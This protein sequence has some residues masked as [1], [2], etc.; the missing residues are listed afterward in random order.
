MLAENGL[1]PIEEI[2]VGDW[3][4]S[5]D[6]QTGEE[7]WEQV[8]RVFQR[9]T[10]ALQELSFIDSEGSQ[11]GI[12]ATAEHPFW[13]EPGL[14]VAAG[15]LARGQKVW[16]RSG[17]AEVQENRSQP[18]VKLVFNFEVRNFHT[19]FVGN[20]GL[21][22]HNSCKDNG[23]KPNN[24]DAKPHGSP[25]HNNA[26]DDYIDN[27]PDSSKNIRKNQAQVDVNG[28]KVGNN[29]PDVQFDDNKVHYNVE[30]DNRSSSSAKHGEVLRNNDPDSVVELHKL[31]P[32]GN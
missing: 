2:A 9:E 1:V 8:T 23:P 12:Q 32:G 19:Y 10:D 28:N 13:A 26:I 24:G 14:W 6:D 22:V 21:L 5:R 17:W 16:A 29:R 11:F 31:D 15:E 18:V 25:P 7:G 3:V 4:W 30:F 27:L 20:N